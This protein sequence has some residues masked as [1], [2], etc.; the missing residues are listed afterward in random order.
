MKISELF[1]ELY[2]VKGSKEHCYVQDL[3]WAWKVFTV[4]TGVQAPETWLRDLVLD[5]GI[6]LEEPAKGQPWR[7][8]HVK[9]LALNAGMAKRYAKWRLERIG[10]S[11][12]KERA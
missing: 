12:L 7:G 5:H 1:I 4:E 11:Q 9:G 10:T 6:E 2:F 8:W 3:A